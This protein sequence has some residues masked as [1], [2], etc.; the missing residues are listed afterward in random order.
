MTAYHTYNSDLELMTFPDDLSSYGR[1]EIGMFYDEETLEMFADC[2]INLQQLDLTP[3]E[4]AIILSY[5]VVT[6]GTPNFL[7]NK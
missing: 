2:A 3:E 7:F 6:T 4:A 1:K 5:L